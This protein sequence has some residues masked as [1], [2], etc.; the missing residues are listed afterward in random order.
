MQ[1]VSGALAAA[2]TSRERTTVVRVKADWGRDGTY[3]FD[4]GVFND[5]FSDT[6]EAVGDIGDLSRFVESVSVNRSLSTDLPE[7]AKL[8]TGYGAAEATVTL[9][10]DL[11][12]MS[13]TRALSGYGGVAD[14][15][16]RAT[17][18]VY[19]EIG[20]VGSAG[21]EYVRQF[22]GRIRSV[23][24]DPFGGAVTL[25]A[26]DGR[27][28][29][30][31]PVQL[32][33]PGIA[34]IVTYMNAIAAAQGLTIT[35]TESPLS[36]G[37][38]TPNVAASSDPWAMLQQIVEAEQGIIL[39]DEND[40]LR[41]YSREHMSG[42]A[43]VDTV[44]VSSATFSNLKAL[45][46]SESVDAVANYVSV[47]ATPM[48]LDDPG[49]VIWTAADKLAVGAAATLDVAV[50]LPGPLYALSGLNYQAAKLADG[51][52][53]DIANLGVFVTQ[54]SATQLV[55]HFTNPNSFDAWIVAN[56]TPPGGRVS[57]DSYLDIL[58]QCLRT[59]EQGYLAT[60][61][62]AASTGK[63]GPQ[64]LDVAEN[65]WRQS[66]AAAR[67][68]ALYLV[69]VLKDP[70]PTLSGVQVV[71]DPRRQLADR[72]RVVEPDGLA[73]DADFWLVGIDTTFSASDGLAQSVTLRQA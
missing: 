54:T 2:L 27:E 58:G 37:A 39:F 13:L 41:F 1:S 23:D 15:F 70:H 40:V 64:P 26:L 19:V 52:G 4:P 42:G 25:S 63:W 24:I 18:P 43:A 69:S 7:G 35:Y 11:T 6:F 5:T 14:A 9:A 30:R 57:G 38:N 72:V 29:V 62:D 55:V 59:S 32:P 61:S 49:T 22:T 10:G 71:G 20:A 8:A 28:K 16:R 68:L 47:P 33:V 45:Q 12:G 36:P 67:S 48:L 56:S 50:D 46:S 17:T 31:T 53:G 73:L 3:A 51:S 21:P 66:S 44:T 34:S 60:A 65:P